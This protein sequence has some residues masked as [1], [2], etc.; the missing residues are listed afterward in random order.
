MIRKLPPLTVVGSTTSAMAPP[1]KLGQHGA[2][3]WDDIQ[4]EYAITDR[5]GIEILWQICTTLDRAEQLANEVT[6]DGPCIMVKGALREHPAIK[7]ELAARAFITRNLQRLGLNVEA[8]KPVGRPP[9]GG[10]GW[11]EE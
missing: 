5:G 7:A 4:T 3:L 10:L 6:R 1:R 2:A 9:S 8:V 11:R